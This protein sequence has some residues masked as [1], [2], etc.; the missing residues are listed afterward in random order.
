MPESPAA[1][2]VPPRQPR[3][4]HPHHGP[5]PMAAI[6]GGGALGTLA[7]YGME[8]AVAT[9]GLGFPWATLW[10]NVIGSFVLGVVVTLVAERLPGDR[11]L[12]P[13]VAVG[14]CGGFTTFSTFAV[15]IDQRV[16]HGYGT[17]A[18]AYLAASLLAGFGA[19]LAGT[20]LARGRVLPPAGGPGVPDPDLLAGD[21]PPSGRGATGEPA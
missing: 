19:A 10:V 17:T 8:R 15:E 6:A 2:G 7:R 21:D 13:L 1:S 3:T 20:T 9:D 14:F 18:L 5:G 16:R 4:V 11:W 12:R